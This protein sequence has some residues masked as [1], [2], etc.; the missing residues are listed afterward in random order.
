MAEEE[1]KP[2]TSDP[3]AIAI[4]IGVIGLVLLA[5]VDAVRR[6]LE[7]LFVRVGLGFFEH[8]QEVFGDILP[9]L[10]ILSIIFSAIFIVG[11]AH[12]TRKTNMIRA[13][14]HKELFPQKGVSIAITDSRPE[15]LLNEKWE[16]VLKLIESDTASDWK[17]AILEADIMLE[18]VLD[19]MGYDGETIGEKLKNV[20]P[21]DFETLDYAWEAHKIRNAVAHEG[22][23]FLLNQREARRTIELY[24][25]VFEEFY[26]I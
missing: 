8:A 13:E 19:K 3:V 15:H 5:V 12:F 20:E 25:K 24:K 9:L 2:T 22:S 6:L 23:D 10:K 17:L 4:E 21:S 11:W 16:Q 26:Y 7:S 1:K 18:E 14:E